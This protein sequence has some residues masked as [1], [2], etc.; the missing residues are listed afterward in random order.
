MP[1]FFSTAA[2]AFSVKHKTIVPI[3]RIII[4]RYRLAAFPP[5]INSTF[6]EKKKHF[7]SRNFKKGRHKN[8]F[9]QLPSHGFFS[10]WRIPD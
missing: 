10:P 2:A 7:S 4:L 6:C 8:T 9:C 3:L 1:I 5:T